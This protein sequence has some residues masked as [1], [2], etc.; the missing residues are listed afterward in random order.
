MRQGLPCWRAMSIVSRAASRRGLARAPPG[1][2][3]GRRPA[4]PLPGIVSVEPG[5]AAPAGANGAKHCRPLDSSRLQECE[6]SLTVGLQGAL[7]F[8]LARACGHLRGP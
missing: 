3:P 4:L 1:R 8:R 2:R 5:A 7:R 6:G